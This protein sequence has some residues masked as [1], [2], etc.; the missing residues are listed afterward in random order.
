MGI[1]EISDDEDDSFGM[2][3]VDHIMKKQAAKKKKE[4]EETEVAVDLTKPKKS[5][6]SSKESSSEDVAET[7]AQPAIAEIMED[8]TST[9]SSDLLFAAQELAYIESKKSRKKASGKDDEEI[10]P[11]PILQRNSSTASEDMDDDGFNYGITSGQGGKDSSD[12]EDFE[13]DFS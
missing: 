3:A 12:E 1:P 10:E 8:S 13:P 5:V 6:Q 4:S 9:S 7:D 2:S 11:V